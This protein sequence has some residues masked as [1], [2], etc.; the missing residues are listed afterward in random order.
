V[1]RYKV[2]V[3]VPVSHANGVRQAVGDAGGGTFGDYSFCSF[4]SRGIGRFIAGAGA[5][6]RV[7]E[8]GQ[9]AQVEEERIEVTCDAAVLMQV[10]DA[11]RRA[12]PYEE[13]ALDIWPL[14][15]PADAQKEA[16]P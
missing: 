14:L 5:R 8:V 1:P 11:I 6:P 4:S 10:A 7:G 13:V 3:F 12:H 15:D 9:L 2:V 16:Q